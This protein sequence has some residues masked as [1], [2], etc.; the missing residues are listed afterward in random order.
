MLAKISTLVPLPSFNS[1]MV[2]VEKDSNSRQAQDRHSGMSVLR[3]CRLYHHRDRAQAG[4][5]GQATLHT[6]RPT[7]HNALL[8]DARQ[9]EAAA[10]DA[11]CDDSSAAH[12]QRTCYVDER[13]SSCHQGHAAAQQ[14]LW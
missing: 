14:P 5:F 6:A 12:C 8:L 11:R 2:S 9:P 13:H 4:P 10:F 1:L 7:W 3:A